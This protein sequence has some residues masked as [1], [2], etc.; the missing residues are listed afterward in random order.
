MLKSPEPLSARMLAELK[1]IA[2]PGA[3]LLDPADRWSYG[4]D[5]SRRQGMAQAVILIET[6]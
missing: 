3:L 2:R 4:Y 6:R 5:N 1:A